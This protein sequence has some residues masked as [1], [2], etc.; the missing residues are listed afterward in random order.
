MTTVIEF[1]YPIIDEHRR[2]YIRHPATN[3]NGKWMAVDVNKD[4]GYWEL[5]APIEFDDEEA[6][7][8]A[9]D[10]HNEY[11]KFSKDQILEVLKLSFMV[12]N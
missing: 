1:E 2:H 7:Q 5:I 10:I 8:K 3:K 6:C 4:G 11:H 12:K 9:C